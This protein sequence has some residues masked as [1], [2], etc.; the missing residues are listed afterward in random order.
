MISSTFKCC[1]MLLNSFG[2]TNFKLSLKSCSPLFI[3]S[4]IPTISSMVVSSKTST[5]DLLKKSLTVSFIVFL[6]FSLKTFSFIVE[7]FIMSLS[8]NSLISSI[9]F[10]LFFLTAP[11]IFSGVYSL[12]IIFTAYLLVIYPATPLENTCSNRKYK[13]SVVIIL[14]TYLSYFNFLCYSYLLKLVIHF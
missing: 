6:K 4:S 9:N 2:N 8:T 13:L 12:N 11:P 14:S 10:S 1:P 7:E 5:S 3:V